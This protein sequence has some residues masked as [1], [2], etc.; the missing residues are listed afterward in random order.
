MLMFI[1][2]KW[3]II[4]YLLSGNIL[5]IVKKTK[6]QNKTQNTLKTKSPQNF[7][8]YVHI[9]LLTSLKSAVATTWH[10][11]IYVCLFDKWQNKFIR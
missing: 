6:K 11:H 8:M 5:Y 10:L 2:C 3:L 9:F 4:L 1:P 7:Y